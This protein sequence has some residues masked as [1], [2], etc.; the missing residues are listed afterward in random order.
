M[1]K[2]KVEPILAYDPNQP[3]DSSG[4]FGSG[5]G[6]TASK[7]GY[8]AAG[9]A[10]GAAAVVG[11]IALRK[12]LRKVATRMLRKDLA[13]FH[14]SARRQD[15]AKR[16]AMGQTARWSGSLPRKSSLWKTI[17]E[18]SGLA[19]NAND[20]NAILAYSR[21][22][23]RDREGQFAS[24]GGR[25]PTIG[26]RVGSAA[27]TAAAYTAASLGGMAAG[28]VGGHLLGKALRAKFMRRKAK[29][30]K[31]LDRAS[32]VVPGSV[33]SSTWTRASSGALKAS[34]VSSLHEIYAEVA[35]D[36]VLEAAA[37]EDGKPAGPPKFNI[38]A[39]NGG[40]LSVAKY[41]LPVVLDIDG[42]TFAKSISANMH[43]DKTMIVGHV[44]EKEKD[45]K[46]VRL[47]GLVSGTGPAAKEV[48]GN[49]ANGY[50]W[51]ASIEAVP[52]RR[53]KLVN[54]GET[55][56]VNGQRIEGPFYLAPKSKLFGIAFTPRGA[57]EDT[58]VQIAAAATD[59]QGK[60]DSSMDFEAFCREQGFDPAALSDQQKA[61]LQDVFDALQG[62]DGE[63]EGD[64][65]AG[66]APPPAGAKG[67][68][69][70]ADAF[71]VDDIKAEHSNHMAE[72]EAVF[73]EHEGDIK[74]DK[75][76]AIRAEATSKAKS[77]KTTALKERWPTVRYQAELIRAQADTRVKLVQAE[78]P[79]GPAIHAVEHDVSGPVIEAA[80]SATLGLP[81]YEKAYKPEVLD[82]AHRDFRNISLHQAMIICAE[83]NG[84]HRREFRV[85]T[86][87]IREILRFSMAPEIHAASTLSLPGILSN[88]ANKELLAGYDLG[89][90]YSV[91]KK[92]AR[93]KSVND[94]KA[95]TSYRLNDNFEYEKVG[96]DGLIKHGKVSEESY[97]R[98]ARTY[99]KMFTLTRQNIIDDDLGALDEI[100]T[101]LG[102]GSAR[103]FTKL[104]WTTFLSN[105]D[106]NSTTFFSAARGNYISGSTTN[107]G[108]DGVGLQLGIDAF[109]LLKTPEGQLAGYEPTMIL[110]PPALS[111]SAKR[112]YTETTPTQAS[113]V[114][115]YAGKYEPVEVV[116]LQDSTI[117]NYS[118]TAWWLMTD[119]RIIAAI[120]VSFLN[121]QE[122]PT[123]EQAEADFNTL[124][125]QMRGY[126]D[127]G[128]D[129]ADWL[130]G[131]KSKGAA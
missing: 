32:G 76:A 130:A 30:R 75:F 18:K 72:L 98:Q 33:S 91:W 58:Q 95:V 21:D 110:H 120:V 78:R 13:K 71:D 27:K 122:S 124:G 7:I 20:P 126:H 35:E 127:F 22:Q 81:G 34:A 55:A 44:T 87:N 83:A 70:A 9:A 64:P 36:V 15:R 101:R 93:T 26:E 65:G 24:G 46:H 118:T 48:L 107:L 79:T 2:R 53:V 57:D 8:A 60:E 40:L 28:Y 3:R 100:R 66:G 51:K 54:V 128:V 112:L 19:A 94:F 31:A 92:I 4:R 68:Q 49:A 41:D 108:I 97:T 23:S 85:T 52:T 11:G 5:G 29:V 99:A 104:F 113:E 89:P 74:A 131:L 43:H 25:S 117:A 62:G 114:N 45:G 115:V 109:K 10:A 77:L 37:I 125:I 17:V 14:Q 111:V 1:A 82:I 116:W 119:P 42:I 121:G 80:L 63:G 90:Q 88:I 6:S 102:A 39:Y 38:L 59:A 86:G 56:T 67:Q 69:M 106:R 123:V 47:K 84:Y 50:P 103:A 129:F 12:K 61:F 96:A 105:L 16:H 73:A